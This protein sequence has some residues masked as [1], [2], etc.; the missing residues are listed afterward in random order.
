MQ[1]IYS[2][3]YMNKAED[4]LKAIDYLIIKLIS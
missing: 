2:H 3:T 4:K 1:W